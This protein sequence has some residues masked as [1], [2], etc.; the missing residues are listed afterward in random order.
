MNAPIT[1]EK[2]FLSSILVPWT[3]Q[4]RYSEESRR[5]TCTKSE[6]VAGYAQAL[7]LRHDVSDVAKWAIEKHIY[8]CLSKTRL[9]KV[10]G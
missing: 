8:R 9:T 2:R 6:W 5:H 3:E 7:A 4:R 10:K 1:N